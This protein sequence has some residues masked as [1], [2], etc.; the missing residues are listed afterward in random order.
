MAGQCGLERVRVGRQLVHLAG[1]EIAD[2]PNLG[3]MVSAAG[4]QLL[5]VGREEDAGDV[6]FVGVELR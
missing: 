6:F 3:C 1:L 5:Y 4:G 2:F